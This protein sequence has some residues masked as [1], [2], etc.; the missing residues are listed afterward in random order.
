M[1]RSQRLLKSVHVTGSVA[2]NRAFGEKLQP[3]D[4]DRSIDLFSDK[5]GDEGWWAGLKKKLRPPDNDDDDD[6]SRDMMLIAF[7]IL[8]LGAAAGVYLQKDIREILG[9]YP[10]ID[11]KSFSEMAG[12]GRVVRVLIVRV[13][14]STETQH[15]ALVE[16]SSGQIFLMFVGNVDHFMKCLEGNSGI[17][18]SDLKIEFKSRKHSLDLAHSFA[19]VISKLTLSAMF[20]FLVYS[21]LKSSG[22]K[23]P[24]NPMDFL[25]GSGIGDFNKS[26]ATKFNIEKNIKLSFKDVA[27]NEQA[28]LEMME[29]VDFLKNP[30]RY[31]DLGAKIPK[32]ALLAGPPGTGKTLLAKC[33]AGEAGVNFLTTSGYMIVKEGR[34]SWSCLWVSGPPESGICSR[35][36]G[37]M[38]LL[39]SLLTRSMQWA[40]S[41]T[42]RWEAGTTR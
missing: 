38:P 40:R 26:K 36:L 5:K 30:Q 17:F 8:A 39:L 34:S 31:K 18:S 13:E 35:R 6:G 15:R 25:G 1:T 21:Q 9:L 23:K 24:G 4:I 11:F 14:G 29:F 10:T 22:K 16:N 12:S 7:V 20:G 3:V 42:R 2:I 32:G 33:C 41:E 19:S 37:R 27:G 28:K